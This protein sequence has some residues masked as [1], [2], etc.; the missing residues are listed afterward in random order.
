MSW[1]L[2]H[3][4]LCLHM[5]KLVFSSFDLSKILNNRMLF[6]LF[7]AQVLIVGEDEHGPDWAG[8]LT[9]CHYVH[10]VERGQGVQREMLVGAAVEPLV[11]SKGM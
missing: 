10:R 5:F 9:P 6:E 3:R 11:V 7:F 4:F 8:E 1:Q 2:N